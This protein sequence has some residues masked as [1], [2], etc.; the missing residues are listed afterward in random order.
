M[1]MLF[2]IWCSEIAGFRARSRGP[3][4]RIEAVGMRVSGSGFRI[5]IGS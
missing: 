3:G 1:T 5:I 2:G 4:S